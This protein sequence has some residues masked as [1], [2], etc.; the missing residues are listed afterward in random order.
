MFKVPSTTVLAKS[1]AARSDVA[2]R[3]FLVNPNVK[4]LVDGGGS[5]LADEEQLKKS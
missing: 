4:S 1:A 2:L 3:I 5:A